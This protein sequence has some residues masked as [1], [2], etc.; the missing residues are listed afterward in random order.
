MKKLMILGMV[1]LLSLALISCK[2]L[3][4]LKGLLHEDPSGFKTLAA[5]ESKVLIIFV[6][7]SDKNFRLN[8]YNFNNLE[9]LC[10]RGEKEEDR[11]AMEYGIY[12]SGFQ[13]AEWVPGEGLRVMFS[14]F[15]DGRELTKKEFWQMVEPF[16]VLLLEQ[17]KTNLE[18]THEVALEFGIIGQEAPVGHW[19]S[20]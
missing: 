19:S 7:E 12:G 4:E 15:G 6:Y 3:K 5:Y 10:I 13:P 20:V 17:K 2:E 11:A 18:A 8:I 16:K 1:V 14:M 9:Y